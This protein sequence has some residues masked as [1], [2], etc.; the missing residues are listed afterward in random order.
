ME[1]HRWLLLVPSHLRQEME[2]FGD[3]KENCKRQCTDYFNLPAAHLASAKWSIERHCV[4]KWMDCVVVLFADGCAWNWIGTNCS[5]LTWGEPQAMF[6]KY[7]SE[8]ILAILVPSTHNDMWFRSST[9][10]SFPA[11]PAGGAFN[12]LIFVLFNS[13][14]VVAV[15]DRSPVW[16]NTWLG[17]D[18]LYVPIAVP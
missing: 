9:M 18:S 16:N 10:A 6:L 3:R 2:E 17:N 13:W 7:N 4:V 5:F 12:S 1:N 8:K 14:F 11:L 15:T